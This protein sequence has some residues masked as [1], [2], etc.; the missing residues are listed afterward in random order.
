MSATKTEEK[1]VIKF[2]EKDLNLEPDDPRYED[3]MRCVRTYWA[4]AI[5]L[6]THEQEEMTEYLRKHDYV[7]GPSAKKT[8]TSHKLYR[9]TMRAYHTFGPEGLSWP[10]YL[11]L[12]SIY[13]SLPRVYIASILDR[14]GDNAYE[15]AFEDCTKEYLRAVSNTE[16]TLTTATK[17]SLKIPRTGKILIN[18]PAAATKGAMSL[19]VDDEDAASGVEEEVTVFNPVRQT[20]QS[21]E[22]AK[23]PRAFS[24]N[25]AI[26]P[27]R[28]RRATDNG[29]FNIDHIVTGVKSSLNIQRFADAAKPASTAAEKPRMTN[30]DL[31]EM[32]EDAKM[33]KET[34]MRNEAKIDAGNTKLDGFISEM[35][36]F[37]TAFANTA[38]IPLPIEVIDDDDNDNHE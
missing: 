23:R 34:S 3:G 29:G 28:T 10:I 9:A 33:A 13:D 15:D 27:K 21:L 19:T 35:R 14:F 2:D 17:T 16:G 30:S 37:M 6:E 18:K 12:A 20:K 8:A 5:K 26:E 25:L 31:F 24:D 1:K 32:K 22:E 4:Q 7:L 11:I 38:G 36:Q